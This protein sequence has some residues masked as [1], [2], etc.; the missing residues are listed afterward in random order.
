[1]IYDDDPA[2]RVYHGWLRPELPDRLFP[3]RHLATQRSR[4]AVSAPDAAG[5]LTS[6]PASR[7]RRRGQNRVTV[8]WVPHPDGPEQLYLRLGF[9]SIGQTYHGQTVAE[10]FLDWPAAGVTL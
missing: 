9:T 4:L 7:P 6:N 10:R 2:R 5:A 8:L 3:L 1:M